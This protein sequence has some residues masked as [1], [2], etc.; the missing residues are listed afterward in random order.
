MNARLGTRLRALE[1]SLPVT[2]RPRPA[3][4]IVASDQE[5]AEAHKLLR[6]EG[7]DPDPS[8]VAIIR[9]VGV[10]PGPN[11]PAIRERIGNQ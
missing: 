11:H 2:A 1:R 3:I 4:R 9:L 10:L 5:E 7:F 6:A 8:A